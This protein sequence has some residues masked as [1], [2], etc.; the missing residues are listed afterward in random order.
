MK[1]A[2]VFA[3]V[4]LSFNVLHASEFKAI[5]NANT[6]IWNPNDRVST[7]KI[8]QTTSNGFQVIDNASGQIVNVVNNDLQLEFLVGED[9]TYRIIVLPNGNPPIIIDVHKPR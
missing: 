3:A 9:V 8:T 5:S 4:F 7:G 1:K 6:V 2:T